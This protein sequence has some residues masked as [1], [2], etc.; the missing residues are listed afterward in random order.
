MN[1]RNK[2]QGAF[3]TLLFMWNCGNQQPPFGLQP[4]DTMGIIRQ[5]LRHFCP[6]CGRVIHMLPVTQLM[7]DDIVQNFR[8]CQYQKTVEIEVSFAAA[9]APA[10]M[11]AADGDTAI[12]NSRNLGPVGCPIRNDLFGLLG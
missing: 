7:D 5:D 9:A 11:L 6:E 4:M 1:M 3:C 2:K 12:G 8:R 10:G